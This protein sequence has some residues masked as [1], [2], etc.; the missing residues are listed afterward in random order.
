M[1][2][3]LIDIMVTNERV[4]TSVS[5]DHY[6]YDTQTKQLVKMTGGT[7]AFRYD[8]NKLAVSTEPLFA[9]RHQTGHNRSQIMEW[10]DANKDDFKLQILD[11]GVM[12]LA[13]SFDEGK[14]QELEDSLYNHRFEY[15]II[16]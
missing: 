4:R 12:H 7:L 13:L 3:V 6:W 16:G 15:D 11:G 9:I 8:G 2:V 10:Y 14:K 1:G 5:S